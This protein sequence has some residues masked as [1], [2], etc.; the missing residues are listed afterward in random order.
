MQY[1]AIFA[2]SKMMKISL[3]NFD[4]FDIVAQNID[5]GYKLEMSWR[6]KIG[7]PL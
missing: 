7:I 6:G 1:T 2:P 4:D 3:E 5:S